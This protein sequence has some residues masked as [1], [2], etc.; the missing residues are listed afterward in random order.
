MDVDTGYKYI[1]KFRR[2]IIS[3]MM[4]SNDYISKINFKLKK[5]NG[6]LV[7]FNGQ[8]IIFRLSITEFYFFQ[9]TLISSQYSPKKKTESQT[10]PKVDPSNCLSSILQNFKDTIRNWFHLK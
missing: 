10:I 9:M 6:E 2:G 8:S 5:D 1:E 4:S 3:Y 7:S